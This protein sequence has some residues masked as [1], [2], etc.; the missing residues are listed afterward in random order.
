V[1]FEIT[2]HQAARILEIVYPAQPSADDIVRYVLEAKQAMKRFVG[3]WCC[4]V[5]QR[6]LVVLPPD[7]AGEVARLNAYAAQHGMACSARVVSSAVAELQVT[8][9]AR[10]SIPVPV[11]TFQDREQAIT[12]LREQLELTTSRPG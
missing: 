6:A 12:W 3:P 5:V 7:L 4:L 2:E 9:L 10:T 8:R 11:R 1:P